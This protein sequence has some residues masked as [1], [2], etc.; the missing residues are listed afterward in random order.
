MRY[1][2][3]LT[4]QYISIKD[5]PENIAKHLI[6]KTCEVE[7]SIVRTIPQDVVIGKVTATSKHPQADKLMICQVDCGAKG[8]FQICTGG[9]NVV[10]DSFVPVAIPGC[11]LPVIDLKIEPRKL[12]GEDSNG[13]ICSKGEVGIN[14]DEEQHWIRTLQY[15]PSVPAE[16]RVQLADFDDL[17]D[18]D[19]GTPLGQKYPWL[20][21][22]IFDVD[23]KTVTHRPDLTGHF[24]L[25]W[26]L[27]AIY[28]LHAADRIAWNALPK[29]MHDHTHTSFAE[30]TA[31]AQQHAI[32]QHISCAGVQVYSTILLEGCAVTRSSLLTRMILTDCGASPK[33]N[34]VDFSQYVMLLTGQPIHTF[35]A[36]TIQ[37]SI[38]VRYAKD[39]EQ[40][41]DLKGVT[42]SLLASDIV[43]ADSAGVLAL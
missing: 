38:E 36:D 34:W 3:S 31:H 8:K 1:H 28:G 16:Q 2:S 26:E 43:I 18:A 5:A 4:K 11:Y 40:F 14:E 13:M 42:H 35:D 29:L 21:R 10:A 9:E 15:G 27:N 20:E 37:G 32:P 41:T 12:R 7:E 39:G 19:C 33:N 23:N 22:Y 24:G 25:A 6:L 17:T 30:M